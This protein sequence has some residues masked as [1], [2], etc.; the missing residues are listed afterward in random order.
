[1]QPGGDKSSPPPPFLLNVHGKQALSSNN[2]FFMQVG[3]SWRSSL[4]RESICAM[5]ICKPWMI[6]LYA[7]QILLLLEHFRFITT[8]HYLLLL[9]LA[10]HY[11]NFWRKKSLIIPNW[12]VTTLIPLSEGPS[13]PLFLSFSFS[14]PR[15]HYTNKCSQDGTQGVVQDFPEIGPFFPS[16]PPPSLSLFPPTRLYKYL[17]RPRLLLPISNLC[18][19]A[20]HSYTLKEVL[21]AFRC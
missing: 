17:S 1:M 6:Y 20:Q 7:A 9:S 10:L 14:L 11:M 2:N 19:C 8:L 13:P 4:Y 21:Y 15:F 18:A 3:E 16:R 5:H 12:F